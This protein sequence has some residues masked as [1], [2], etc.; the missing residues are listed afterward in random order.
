MSA[1]VATADRMPDDDLAVLIALEDG[2]VWTGFH[3]GDDGWR[4]VSAD[5]VGQE[6]RY[7]MDFPEPPH[8]IGVT[9]P[10]V[11]EVAEG[12]VRSCLGDLIATIALHTDCMTNTIDREALDP[13]IERAEDL[14]GKT[15]E[16]IAA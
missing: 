5:P 2:E 6:V 10:T 11:D 3:D 14:L 13:Y 15:A 4:Y 12:D 16:E 7:W 8:R 9:G 1:W